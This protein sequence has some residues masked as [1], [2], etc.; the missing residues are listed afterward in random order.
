M[1]GCL[2]LQRGFAYVGH[3]LA[4]LLKEKYGVTEFCG[5]VYL[6]SSYEFLKSQN[7][8]A[9]GTLLLDEDIHE[10][11]KNEKVDPD[12]LSHLEKTYGIPFLWPLLAVDRVLMFGQLV[13]E[14]P[15]NALP[16]THEE[17]LR[18]LQAHA[19]AIIAM[20]DEE[21]PDFLF[22]SVL[23]A[24]GSQLLYYV[25]KARG[26]NII[27]VEPTCV[28]DRYI[29]SHA[30]DTFTSVDDRLLNRADPVPA[31]SPSWDQAK[32][33]LEEFRARPIPYYATLTPSAQPVTRRRQMK[34]LK[35]ARIARSVGAY[36]RNIASHFTRRDRLDYSYI[37]PWNQLKDAVKR[38]ARNTVGLNDL[39]D[40]IDPNDEFAFFPLHLEPEISILLLAPYRTDQISLIRSIARSL[41][42]QFKLYV[43]EHPEMVPYRPRWFY[44]ELKKNPNVKLIDPSVDGFSLIPRAKLVLDVT[45]TVG[46]EAVMMKRPV[47]MF[48]Y[49]F[50]KTLP[51]VKYCAEIESLPSLVKYQLE[52]FRHDEETLLAMLASIFEDSTEVNLRRLW[53]IER[54][55]VKRRLGLIPLADLLAK[56]LGLAAPR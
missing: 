1:K 21:K 48:G 56:E 45:G 51:T 36:A 20:L 14:Y 32:R 55:P 15:H 18:I 6:R 28:R 46:W 24:I 11:F 49:W 47:I 19:R 30:Y 35:P 25:A 41:P 9:Y 39:Y 42:V 17:M 27:F 43:K 5:Y 2:L 44:R 12:Y 54:D 16:Y 40:P 4:C 37:S 31:S 53:E 10:G 34:F 13:R 38:R 50:F 23:G 7:E 22:C 26:I 29:L 33:Y 3:D 8:I 52:Q